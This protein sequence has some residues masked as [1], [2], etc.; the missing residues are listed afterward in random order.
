MTFEGY[1]GGDFKC[2]FPGCIAEITV[3]IP[4]DSSPHFILEN[5]RGDG[6]Q[7]GEG[8]YDNMHFCPAHAGQTKEQMHKIADDNYRKATDW[9]RHISVPIADEP[10]SADGQ[11]RDTPQE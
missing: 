6:W 8:N 4:D 7:E 11:C 2:D 1:Q 9:S 10:Q 3:T 5:L